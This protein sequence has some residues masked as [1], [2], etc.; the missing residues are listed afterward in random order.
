MTEMLTI[1]PR[2]CPEC[3]EMAQKKMHEHPG[4]STVYSYCTHNAT[5]AEIGIQDG[6]PVFWVLFSPLSQRQAEQLSNAM[7]ASQHMKTAPPGTAIN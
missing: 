7:A 3:L 4:K 5:H 2:L 1:Q 6:E